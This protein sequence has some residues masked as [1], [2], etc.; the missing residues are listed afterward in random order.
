M[1]RR[2]LNLLTALSLLLFVAVCVMWVRSYFAADQIGVANARAYVRCA[3]IHGGSL[4]VCSTND[5]HRQPDRRWQVR[6][7]KPDVFAPTAADLRTMGAERW[8]V[9]GI[10]HFAR[11]RVKSPSLSG[12]G[13]TLL[14]VPLWLP[15]AAS[16][17]FAIAAGALVFRTRRRTRTGRCAAC[18]YD[19]R[20]TPARC[21]ECGLPAPAPDARRAA[22]VAGWVRRADRRN[23]L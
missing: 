12:A 19:L 2:L 8:S 16:G 17:C 18:G 22:G 6:T 21:P 7:V 5:A 9:A 1:R 3:A 11:D 13:Y 4:F 14:V 10:I 20:A 23:G 15:A